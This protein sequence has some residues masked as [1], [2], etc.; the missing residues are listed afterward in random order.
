MDMETVQ[1]SY[2]ALLPEIKM[3]TAHSH[4]SAEDVSKVLQISVAQVERLMAQLTGS[5]LPIDE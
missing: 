2:E 4:L 5:G 1:H 3:L